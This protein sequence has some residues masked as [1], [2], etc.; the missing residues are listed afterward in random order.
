MVY[1]RHLYLTQCHKEFLLY[2]SISLSF[3]D[4]ETNYQMKTLIRTFSHSHNGQV[5]QVRK[6]L[7]SLSSHEFPFVPFI[8]VGNSFS[9]CPNGI[10]QSKKGRISC[11]QEVLLALKFQRH[12]RLTPQRP[13]AHSRQVDR[14]GWGPPAEFF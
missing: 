6:I 1:L 3:L 9:E 4:L 2:F 7:S 5:E 11:G 14:T 8:I 13:P 10:K 12:R